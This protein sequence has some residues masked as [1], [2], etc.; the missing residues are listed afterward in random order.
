MDNNK[1]IKVVSMVKG[2]VGVS[3]PDLRFK[4]DWPRM[5][6][7]IPVDMNILQEAIFDP[8]FSRMIKDG[9]LLIDDKDARIELGLESS[10]EDENINIVL[11]EM[12]MLK[13][14]KVSGLDEFETTLKKMSG[15]QRKTL[16]EIAIEKEIDS[17]DKTEL[18]NKYSGIDVRRTIDLNRKDKEVIR[19][20]VDESEKAPN[21][22]TR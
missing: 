19:E 14:L 16:A 13:L 20:S 6:T 12:Q 11:N 18:I 17:Y 15:A 9:V 8:G 5:G 2:R 22:I 7:V 21:R 3:L 1:K 10:N 4:R